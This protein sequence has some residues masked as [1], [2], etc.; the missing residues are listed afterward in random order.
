MCHNGVTGLQHSDDLSVVRVRQI[1]NMI[2]V[3]K[4]L[5]R[6]LIERLLETDWFVTNGST[7]RA[8][9]VI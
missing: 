7:N 2:E 8:V 1:I 5:E 9:G 4:S 3:I 6:L